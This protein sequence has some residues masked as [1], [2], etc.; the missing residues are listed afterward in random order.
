MWKGLT[1]NIVSRW[2][3]AGVI[4]KDDAELYCYGVQQGGLVLLNIITSL[5]IGVWNQAVLET[6][7]FLIAYIPLR[8]FAG[9]YH[10]KNT[11]RC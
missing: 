4:E 5:M 1:Q 9:G 11:K 6:V 7:L 3:A 2:V 8:S 10:A